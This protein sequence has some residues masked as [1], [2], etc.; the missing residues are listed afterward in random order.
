MKR[1]LVNPFAAL[2]VGLVLRLFF[3]FKFPADSG[4]TSLYE[5]LAENWLKHGVYGVL[6]DGRLTPGAVRMPGYPA[7]L[8][9][10]YFFA[11]RTGAAARLWVMIGQVAVDLATCLLTMLLAALLSRVTGGDRNRLQARALWFAATCPFLANYAAVPLTEICAA[12]FTAAALLFLVLQAQAAG[13]FPV[14]LPRSW[15]RFGDFLSRH[16]FETTGILGALLVGLGTLIRPE[17]PLLL[18]AS[19]IV[20]G[21]LLLSKRKPGRW[22]RTLALTGIA[23]LVPLVPWAVRNAVTIHEAQWLTPRYSELPGEL[24]PDGFIAWEKTWLYRFRDVYLVP[25]KLNEEPIRLDDLP[26]GAF[27]TPGEKQRIA[28]ALGEYNGTL[29]FTADQDA[30]FAAIARERTAR[31]PLRTYLA[32]P[33]ARAL[34]MW[35]TPRIELLPFSGRFFPLQQSLAE[36]PVDFTVTLG[37]FVLNFLYAGLAL[38]GAVYLLRSSPSARPGVALLLGYVLLRTAFLTTIETP[39]PRYVVSCLPILLA[40][41]AQARIR[42]ASRT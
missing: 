4:D 11:G 28:A 7:F 17:M 34:T 21:L 39:E 35:F 19:W 6:A 20:L 37:F 12:F 15:R 13:G 10:T 9:V 23:C 41:A 30:V 29:T 16:V 33:L 25:W 27:D 14:F 3:V 38:W 32:I 26:A 42:P 5:Q 36:D 2:S 8:A 18:F 24:V 31:H 1:L 22:I 40:L